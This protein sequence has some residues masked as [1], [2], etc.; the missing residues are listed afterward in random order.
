MQHLFSQSSLN[1]E[2]PHF[3]AFYTQVPETFLS[4]VALQEGSSGFS[5][6]EFLVFLHVISDRLRSDLCEQH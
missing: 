6:F 5:L 2:H 4:T 1:L 3:T